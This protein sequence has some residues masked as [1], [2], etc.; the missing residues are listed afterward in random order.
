MH[1]LAYMQTRHTSFVP[2]FK[3]H[4]WKSLVAT[5]VAKVSTIQKILHRQDRF[6]TSPTVDHCFTYLNRTNYSD[7]RF[8]YTNSS[9]KTET[10]YHTQPNHDVFVFF[11]VF[12]FIFS[13]KRHLLY[14]FVHFIHNLDPRIGSWGKF[15]SHMTVR[16]HH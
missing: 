3:A 13:Y 6:T 10:R 15:E 4:I 12:R 2:P 14:F 1:R 7:R 5:V 11:L 8:F 16:F 9:S